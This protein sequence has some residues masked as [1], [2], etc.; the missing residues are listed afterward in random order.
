MTRKLILIVM[1][2]VFTFISVGA[3]LAMDQGNKRKGKYI[4]R[5]VYKACY[6]RGEVT[7]VKPPL[8]PDAKTQEQWTAL[9]DNKNF[10]EF[11]CQQEWSNLSD[12]DIVDIYTYLYAHAADSPTPLKCK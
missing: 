10:T 5:K 11:G 1:A 6:E 3:V 8:N 12:S 9:F 4:Y 7:E 2:T